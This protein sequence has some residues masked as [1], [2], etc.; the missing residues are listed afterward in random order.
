MTDKE[1]IFDMIFS[2]NYQ[3]TGIEL[4]RHTL[5]LSD[6]QIFAECFGRFVKMVYEEVQKP[7]ECTEVDFAF[8]IF[9]ISIVYERYLRLEDCFCIKQKE[10]DIYEVPRECKTSLKTFCH[11]LYCII[12][13]IFE[14]LKQEQ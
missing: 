13:P 11:K 7:I 3:E 14:K 8:S 1:K 9:D 12:E 2:Y 10:Q 6:Y 5:G 4:A